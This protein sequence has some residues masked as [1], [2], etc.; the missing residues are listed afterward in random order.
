MDSLR[1]NKRARLEE[2]IGTISLITPME[3]K[4]DAFDV[5]FVENRVAKYVSGPLTPEPEVELH[6]HVLPTDVYETEDEEEEQIFVGSID[7]G[8]TSSRFLIF[9][10]HGEPVA[11]HQI[12]FDNLY[13]QSG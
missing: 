7:Q 6:E 1:D 2:D 11:N 5:E 13:P 10:V 12:E 4:S 3:E 9:N 8:T